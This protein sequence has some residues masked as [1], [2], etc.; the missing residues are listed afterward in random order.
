MRAA[1]THVRIPLE[2][3]LCRHYPF[4]P[5]YSGRSAPAR[6]CSVARLVRS[7]LELARAV[8]AALRQGLTPTNFPTRV[9][10]FARYAAVDREALL[11][12]INMFEFASDEQ[13][14]VVHRMVT[15]HMF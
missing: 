3:P 4:A 15:A 14:S 11:P 7:R 1:V 9:K 2:C 10:E 5:L 8:R 6:A 12:L 13:V